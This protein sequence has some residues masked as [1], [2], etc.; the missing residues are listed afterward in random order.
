MWLLT[1][2][3][4]KIAK[5]DGEQSEELIG[6]TY[7]GDLARALFILSHRSDFE[8]KKPDR[9]GSIYYVVVGATKI[10]KLEDAAIAAGHMEQIEDLVFPGFEG[11]D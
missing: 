8:N 5:A 11:S 6:M 9:K 3:Q 1:C 2:R 4:V 7:D 10:P